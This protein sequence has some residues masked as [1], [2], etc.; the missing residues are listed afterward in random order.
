MAGS[1]W[2][3]EPP[4]DPAWWSEPTRDVPLFPLGDI[5]DIAA[6]KP[7]HQEKEPVMEDASTTSADEPRDTAEAYEQMWEAAAAR[8]RAAEDADTL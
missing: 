1:D 7:S 3:Y 5:P 4:R 8:D 6:K 2:W